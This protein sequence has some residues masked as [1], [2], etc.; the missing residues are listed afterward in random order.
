MLASGE[1]IF[2]VISSFLFLEIHTKRFS[3]GDLAVATWWYLI[4]ARLVPGC[5]GGL[6][7][8]LMSGVVSLLHTQRSGSL[9]HCQ[10]DTTRATDS[11]TWK[12][13]GQRR[14]D[15]DYDALSPVRFHMRCAKYLSSGV[16]K[17]H[18][19]CKPHSSLDPGF[20]SKG[21][22]SFQTLRVC[23]VFSRVSHVLNRAK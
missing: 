5:P 2:P 14:T 1:S 20:I 10:S 3:S 6:P 16:T 19:S 22:Y 17:Y 7:P 8:P 15:H 4:M 9:Q 21:F 11:T 23:C 13:H 18:V 12:V